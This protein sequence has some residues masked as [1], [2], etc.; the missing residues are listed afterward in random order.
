MK[1]FLENT[2]QISPLPNLSSE[3][4]AGFQRTEYGPN[5]LLTV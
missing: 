1:H 5:L 2:I 4:E 3:L